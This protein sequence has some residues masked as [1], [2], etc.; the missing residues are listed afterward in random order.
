MWCSTCQHDVS[1][2]AGG[3]DS[4]VA[5]TACGTALTA[6]NSKRLAKPQLPDEDWQIEADIRSVQRLIDSLRRTR[7]D[8]SAGMAGPHLPPAADPAAVLDRPI[9]PTPRT[10]LAAWTLLS[11]GLAVFAC[12]AVLLAWSL[13]AEREDLWPIGL[14][15][16]LAGQAVLIVGLVFQLE[17]VWQSNRQTAATL[18]ALDGELVRART[19]SDRPD[20]TCVGAKA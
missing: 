16:A 14:P 13:I 7:L 15:L 20:R 9:P 1:A 4:L 12:G 18:S 3:D 17:V 6:G 8:A 11:L 5:C 19:W 2:A 10:N